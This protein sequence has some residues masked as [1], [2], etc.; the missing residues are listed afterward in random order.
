[1][2]RCVEC[3]RENAT[4]LL[5]TGDCVCADCIENSEN[6][7]FCENCGI[8]MPTG[9]TEGAVRRCSFCLPLED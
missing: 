5:S 9:I 6:Y 4:F 7:T 1:M 3:G 2:A 8:A